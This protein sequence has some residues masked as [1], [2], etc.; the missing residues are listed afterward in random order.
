MDVPG[1][2][3]VVSDAGR[4]AR[5]MKAHDSFGYR[6]V[7]LRIGGKRRRAMVHRLVMEVFVGPSEMDV[8]HL[9]G[10]RD[11][12]RLENLVYATKQENEAHKVEHGT[13]RSGEQVHLAKLTEEDV[14]KMR[15]LYKAGVRP[16]T[17]AMIYGVTRENVHCVVSGKTWK[18]VA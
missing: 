6:R 4:V 10:V 18:H 7:A 16:T 1:S 13:R 17:L 15:R 12:N 11:D 3:Y 9:N 2:E 14:R 5:L 8:A